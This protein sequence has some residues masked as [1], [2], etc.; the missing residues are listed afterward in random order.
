MN[1]TQKKKKCTVSSTTIA[2]WIRKRSISWLTL[3]FLLIP[4]FANAQESTKVRKVDL[5]RKTVIQDEVTLRIKVTGVDGKPIMALKEDDFNIQ[6]TDLVDP[7]K[8]EDDVIIKPFTPSSFTSSTSPPSYSDVAID[9]TSAEETIPSPAYMIVLLDASGSMQCSGDLNDPTENCGEVAIG[10]RKFDAAISAIKTFTQVAGK[11]KGDNTQVSI[12]PFGFGCE[13]EDSVDDKLSVTP[14]TKDSTVLNKF[15]LVSD[16]RIEQQLNDLQKKIPTCSTNIYDSLIE[17]VRFLNNRGDDRFYPEDEEG[18]PIEP[19]PRL[20]V[21]L[22][23]DG[24]DT[25][26][27]DPN[28]EDARRKQQKKLDELKAIVERNEQLNI[29]TLAYGLTPK[30][31]GKKY[32]LGRDATWNDIGKKFPAEEYLDLQGLQGIGELTPGLFAVSGDEREIAQEL[33]SF[34]DAELGEY[35]IKYKHPNPRRAG[36]YQVA[37]AAENVFSE[38]EE[39][40][41]IIFGKFASRN[42]YLGSLFLLLVAGLLCFIPYEIWRRKLTHLD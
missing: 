8:S 35:E 31:L 19:K 34:L 20:A 7:K 30:Q 18:N 23:S 13:Y 4:S 36:L 24:Y 3:G 41:T 11:R 26:Y 15:L 42:I 25:V 9:F 40:R 6:I 33:K 16:A 27:K 12:V 10:K 28:E 21:I 29:H 37:V 2:F 1:L 14:L 22:L 39:Y 32:E 38:P 5:V 17:S